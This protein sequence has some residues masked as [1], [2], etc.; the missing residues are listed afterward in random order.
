MENFPFFVLVVIFVTSVIITWSAGITLTKTTSTIDSRFKLGDALGGLILLGISSSLPEMAVV[1]SAAHAR[2]IPVILGTILGGLAIK[3]LIIVIFDLFQRRKKPLSYL[4]GSSILSL[5]TFFPIVMTMIALLAT[6][7]PTGNGFLNFNPFSLFI[8]L[9]WLGGLFI[10]NKARKI[11]SLNRTVE[12][13]LP[14]RKHGERQAKESH[15]F[16]VGKS[17]IYVIA[18][19]LGVCFV[20]LLAGVLL[21]KTG[22]AIAGQLGM[23]TGIFAAT[24]IALVT[25]LPEISTGLE[26]IFI[27]DNHLAVSDVMGGNAFMLTI[28][29][30]ADMVSG[31]S[32]LSQAGAEDIYLALLGIIL[33]GIYAASFLV[34]SR[35]RYFHL[36][37][38]SILVIII[39]AVGMISLS[40]LFS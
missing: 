18:I 29:L 11:R 15:P 23:N 4:V 17:N 12:D 34:K 30:M 14:G 16:Y 3:P 36:G 39:Y 1:I 2:H 28:F 24:I 38:D 27:G 10:I 8:V 7:S 37:L 9:I 31:R 6:I 33:M 20:L 5:E 25:S 22:V 21:E 19:F 26:S 32:V 13:A 35:R 40:R